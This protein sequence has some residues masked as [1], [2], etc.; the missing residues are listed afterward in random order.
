MTDWWQRPYRIVQTNLRMTDALMD[1]REVARQAREFGATVLLFNVGGIFAFYPTALPLHARNPMLT[2]DLLGEMLEAAH[3]QGLKLIGRFDLSKSTRPAYEAHPEWFVHNRRGEPL[4]YN[5]TYQACVN[6]GWYQG[7]AHE[8]IRESLSRYAVDGV[9]FNMFGYRSTDYSGTY[10]GICACRN[11]QARFR[12]MY[13]RELPMREDFSDPSYADYQEFKDR[14]SLALGDDIY[15]TV[16]A[17]RP[18]VVVT[19][20]RTTCD[21]IRMEVQRAVN[22]PTPE[23][24]YQSGEQARWAAAYGRGKNFGSTSANF[25]DF[26]WRFVSETGACHALRF[27]QQLANGASLDYYLLGTL[28]QEDTKPFAA[29]RE[30]FAWHAANEADYAGLENA[31]RIGL[32]HSHK[33]ATYQGATATAVQQAACFRGAY[34]ALLEARLPFDFVSDE[35]MEDVDAGQRLARYD[36]LVLPNVACLDDA[37]AKR[38]DDWVAAGGCLLATGETGLYDG[39]GT[40][41]LGFALASL[42]VSHLVFRRDELRT[43]FRINTDE[44]DFPNTRLLMLDGPYFHAAPRPGAETLLRLLPQQRFGP[45][46][47]CYPEFEASEFPG[48]IIGTHGRGHAIYV[49]WL[50]EWHYHRDSLPDHRSFLVQLATR[51]APPPQVQLTGP[52]PV[53]LTVHRQPHAGRLFVHIVNYSGQ[54][55]NLY[56][57]PVPLRGLRLGIRGASGPAQALVAGREIPCGPSDAAG[58]LWLD[59]PEVRTFEAIS[60]TAGTA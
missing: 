49:P 3:S 13:G 60:V 17:T 46:E 28:I 40:A 44:L 56:E 36:V 52:G 38:L 30:L 20:R 35:R 7:Y 26:A 14:T 54:R 27:A 42:P 59:V 21:M 16:K 33:T 45:P 57:E 48:A 23:W 4:E 25:I 32:Y 53:E 29:V 1:P 43:Y 12:S 51:F 47:F 50:P 37:E 8:I 24:P 31:A 55:N 11:C 9:F 5:G 39:R 34:R 22:R 19:G 2:G 18:N 58:I 10:H 6:G 15:R 41:R